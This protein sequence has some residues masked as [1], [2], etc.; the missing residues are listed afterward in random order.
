MISPPPVSKENTLNFQAIRE[1]LDRVLV[2]V[3]NFVERAS[4]PLFEQRPDLQNYL[5]L[6][7]QVGAWLHRLVMLACADEPGRQPEYAAALF[8]VL[9]SQI[10]LVYTIAFLLED[11]IQRFDWYA[12]A[13]WF[14]AQLKH[15]KH[16][17]EFGSDPAWGKYLDVERESVALL[18]SGIT[19]ST[20]EEADPIRHVRKWR[21]PGRFSA[22][23]R[24]PNLR[25]MFEKLDL[26]LYDELS[27]AAHFT[28]LGTV[29]AGLILESLRVSAGDSWE[30]W[31]RKHRSV[32]VF[33][34][35]ALILAAL[36]EVEMTFRFGAAT[37][38]RFVWQLAGEY[39][40]LVK[41]VYEI[42][43]QRGLL[44]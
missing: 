37:D 25:L 32:A 10:E 27:R 11:P 16:T 18:R 13:G 4:H 33:R 44:S 35:I 19:L 29:D 42:R 3:P 9:R 26:W 6:Q 14:R 34:S 20:N 40:P 36:S 41:E 24:D 31:S 1:K 21:H 39:S 17:K 38:L 30:A 8:P 28:H 2:A 15:E 5:R 43:W 23:V 7:L 22:D 12:K